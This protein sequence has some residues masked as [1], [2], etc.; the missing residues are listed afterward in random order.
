V[1][2]HLLATLLLNEVQKDHRVIQAQSE[3][4][5]ALEK[6]TARI[7]ALEKDAA[8]IASLEEQVALLT[9]LMANRDEPPVTVASR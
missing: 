1:S 6:E 2:Y 5:A 9:T 8:R 3:R 7:A 4:I